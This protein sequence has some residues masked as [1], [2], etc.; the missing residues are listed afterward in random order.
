M[1]H[2]VYKKITYCKELCLLIFT[3]FYQTLS[4]FFSHKKNYKAYFALVGENLT[5][6]LLGK[7]V[8]QETAFNEQPLSVNDNGKCQGSTKE[9]FLTVFPLQWFPVPTF[10]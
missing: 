7:G 5:K 10:V 9:V 3:F 8:E 2:Y 4:I 6:V 1:F